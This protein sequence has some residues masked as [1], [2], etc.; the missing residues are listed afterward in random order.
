MQE[1]CIWQGIHRPNFSVVVPLN[2]AMVSDWNT[3]EARGMLLDHTQAVASRQSRRGMQ[4]HPSRA[5]YS[6]QK[7]PNTVRNVKDSTHKKP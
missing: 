3:R 4:K 1:R 5:Q 7:Q 6:S 2:G